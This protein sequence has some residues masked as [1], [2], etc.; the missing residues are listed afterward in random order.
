M[1][2]LAAGLLM[3]SG[4]LGQFLHV[5]DQNYWK[6]TYIN[7]NRTPKYM[8][9]RQGNGSKTN[10]IKS[11][12]RTNSFLPVPIPNLCLVVPL[13]PLERWQSLIAPR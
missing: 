1:L 13:Y 10:Q 8:Q 5:T 9:Q 11:N 3:A 2:R 4:L 6:K 12:Q 7:R